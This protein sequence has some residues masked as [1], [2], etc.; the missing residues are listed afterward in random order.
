LRMTST[1]TRNCLMSIPDPNFGEEMDSVYLCRI[2]RTT[3]DAFNA[4]TRRRR[5]M[6][7]APRLAAS[8]IGNV[9]APT[10]L[11]WRT[12]QLGDRDTF[13]PQEPPSPAANP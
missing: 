12:A 3:L 6:A 11:T 1:K 5:R 10:V 8:H 13:H 7:R 9:P 4:G 2:A